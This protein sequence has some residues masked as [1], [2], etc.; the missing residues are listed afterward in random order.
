MIKIYTLHSNSSSRKA[1]K[2]LD[3]NNL[4][5]SDQRINMLPPNLQ[6]IKE[7]LSLTENGTDDIIASAS[8]TYGKLIEEGI[9]F[10]SLTLLELSYLI[11]ENPTVLKG[12]I[13]I[14][15]DKLQIGF[16][17]FEMS[18]FIP[19]A[20]KMSIYSKQLE[21]LRFEE[22]QRLERGEL[23]GGGYRI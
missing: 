10:D 21:D 2:W 4:N 7:I 9:D 6:Q 12:P 18:Q 8:I 3:E 14:S 22:D 11:K 17:H 19:R 15:D 23:I 20:K 13:I 5:Y 16:N 1:I